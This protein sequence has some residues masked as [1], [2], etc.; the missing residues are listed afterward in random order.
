MV[1]IQIKFKQCF[2]CP[3]EQKHLSGTRDLVIIPGKFQEQFL[4][5]VIHTVPRMRRP[6]LCGVLVEWV[7]FQHRCEGFGNPKK[8]VS[9]VLAVLATF[10]VMVKPATLKFFI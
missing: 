8:I 3:Q 6:V 7:M 4:H 2:H 1:I 5:V 10:A 9:S